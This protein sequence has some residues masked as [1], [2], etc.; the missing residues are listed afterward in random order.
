MGSSL[1][2]YTKV[3]GMYWERRS[4]NDQMDGVEHG[5]V[6]DILVLQRTTTDLPSASAAS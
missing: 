6:L 3:G 5:Q 1:E 4:V 2:G